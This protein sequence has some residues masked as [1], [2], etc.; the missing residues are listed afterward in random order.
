MFDLTLLQ[1]AF[2]F[3]FSVA[4]G[5][6]GY[7]FWKREAKKEAIESEISQKI[8]KTISEATQESKNKIQGDFESF[9]AHFAIDYEEL[10]D[11][12]KNQQQ[13]IDKLT[14]LLNRQTEAI[15]K[16]YNAQNEEIEI[17]RAELH[18]TQ[19]MLAKCKKKLKRTRDDNEAA[20]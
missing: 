18:K 14:E 13:Q 11:K 9:R 15:R 4:I 3:F 5:Y 10:L 1:D 17:L 16:H 2:N 12:I 6:L 20:R 19:S 8:L 7:L